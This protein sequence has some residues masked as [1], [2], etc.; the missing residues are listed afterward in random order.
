M[1]ELLRPWEQPLSERYWQALL[2]EEGLEEAFV[3]AG[4]NGRP[5]HE[6]DPRWQ[7]LIETMQRGKRVTLPVV[8]YNRGGLLVDWDGMEG[9]V[10][11]S[12]LLKAP[13]PEEEELRNALFEEYVGRKL[14]LKIIEVDPSRN[15]LVFSERAACYDHEEAEALLRSLRPGMVVSGTVTN[16]CPFGAFIDLGGIEGLLHISEFSWGRVDRPEDLLSIGQCVDVY[17][18]SVD[19]DRRRIALSLK[20]LTPNPWESVDERYY[21]GQVLEGEVTNVAGFGIFVALEEGV[22]GLIHISE[23]EEMG[24]QH[25]DQVVTEGE[26]IKVRVLNVDGQQRRIGLGLHLTS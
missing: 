6:P 12:H 19:H 11:T 21:P 18:L 5:R 14:T 4:G 26:R 15:R 23:L 10:P 8:G 20:R 22:E 13:F 3:T 7:E 24:I 9:F 16:L 2:R 25:P 17:I 1:G